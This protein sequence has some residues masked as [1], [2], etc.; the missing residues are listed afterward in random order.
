LLRNP[1]QKGL[2]VIDAR[3]VPSSGVTRIVARVCRSQPLGIEG[4]D[5]EGV[6]RVQVDD[7]PARL[8]A[9]RVVKTIQAQLSNSKTQKDLAGMATTRRTK[10]P[11]VTTFLDLVIEGHPD[12]FVER[13]ITVSALAPA[14][15]RAARERILAATPQK[16]GRVQPTTESVPAED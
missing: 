9:P 10:I 8:H 16:T 11:G 7:A 4:V 3:R 1:S 6:Y 14:A 2:V 13:T 12:N 5:P 15:A